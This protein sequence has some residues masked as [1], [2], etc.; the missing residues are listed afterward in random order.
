MVKMKEK[1]QFTNMVFI[2]INN[3]EYHDRNWSNSTHTDGH[4]DIYVHQSSTNM[5][6]TII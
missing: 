2:K 3:N 4:M 1:S 5:L 6:S